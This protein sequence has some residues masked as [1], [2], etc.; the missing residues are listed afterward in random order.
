MRKSS[1]QVSSINLKTCYGRGAASSC[2]LHLRRGVHG[3]RVRQVMRIASHCVSMYRVHTTNPPFSSLYARRAVVRGVYF[4]ERGCKVRERLC[5]FLFPLPKR[6]RPT[7]WSLLT[8]F[9]RTKFHK[10]RLEKYCT[11]NAIMLL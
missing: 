4:D 5:F 7:K 2:L 6:Q 9:E 3:H 8:S 1:I 11:W 10:C